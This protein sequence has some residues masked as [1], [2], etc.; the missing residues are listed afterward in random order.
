[1]SIII[2]N[3]INFMNQNPKLSNYIVTLNFK[4]GYNVILDAGYDFTKEEFKIARNE[5]L[6]KFT[7]I[8]QG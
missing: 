4:E 8:K 7:P 6:L 3:F 5:L 2:E 1:M